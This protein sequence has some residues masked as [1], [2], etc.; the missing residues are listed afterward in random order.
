MICHK[1]GVVMP[2]R[3][4]TAGDCAM[5]QH[6]TS[7]RSELNSLI[8]QFPGPEWWDPCSPRIGRLYPVIVQA[9]IIIVAVATGKGVGTLGHSLPRR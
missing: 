3:R 1:P 2:P 4:H 7:L 5:G 9:G 6:A 8:Q